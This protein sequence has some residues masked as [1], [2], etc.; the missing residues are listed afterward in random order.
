[1]SATAP[2]KTAKKAAPKRTPTER[3][4]ANVARFEEFRSRARNQNIV[5]A[6]SEI[7]PYVIPADMIG[8]GIKADVEFKIP[9]TLSGRVWLTRLISQMN[10][11]SDVE[12]AAMIPDILIG[13]S[14]EHTFNRILRAFDKEPD[15]DALLFGMTIQIIEHFNGKGAVDVPGGTTAS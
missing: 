6:K 2:K 14:S 13:Y 15:P 11:V 7:E 8:D 1:M 9:E 10:R 5:G 4:T 12:G 3:D